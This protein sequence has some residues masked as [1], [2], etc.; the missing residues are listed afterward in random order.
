MRVHRE[1]AGRQRVRAR[2][3]AWQMAATAA[4]LTAA[5]WPG[6]RGQPRQV[7]Q[8]P[9]LPVPTSPPPAG[10]LE[11]ALEAAAGRLLPIQALLMVALMALA[12]AGRLAE[13]PQEGPA[14][15]A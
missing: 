15:K 7:R 5:R 8:L 3:A 11:R 4:L 13:E 1:T 9:V 14:L 6:E 10:G 2:L 12:E